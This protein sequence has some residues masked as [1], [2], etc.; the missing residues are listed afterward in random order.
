MLERCGSVTLLLLLCGCSRGP[1]HAASPDTLVLELGGSNVPLPES[2][3]RLGVQPRPPREETPQATN[4][5]ATNPPAS[6]APAPA[7]QPAAAADFIEVKLEK[8]Q[9][10]YELAKKHLGSATRWR[11]IAE[12]NHIDEARL[13]KLREGTVIRVPVRKE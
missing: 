8:N 6:D 4:P 13:N 12:F 11:E 7:P 3:Q 9:T 5:P 1:V 2:M 10:L